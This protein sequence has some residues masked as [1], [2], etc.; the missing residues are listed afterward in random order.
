MIVKHV[1]YLLLVRRVLV[2]RLARA[3]AILLLLCLKRAARV[4]IV[5]A[6]HLAAI[7]LSLLLVGRTLGAQK[8]HYVLLLLRVVLVK[9]LKL[10]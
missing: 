9:Q 7:L 6:V 5:T 3:V 1:K 2:A 4:A 8:S 10:S